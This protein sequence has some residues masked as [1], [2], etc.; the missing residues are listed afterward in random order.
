METIET[1]VLV[2]GGGAT[3]VGVARDAAMRGFSTV[4]VERK[5]LA[6]G[7]TGRYH[8]LLHSGGRYAVKDPRA[9]EECAAENVILRRVA[10]DC[11]EDTGGLFVTTPW[12]DPDFG[13]RFLAGCAATGVG[14]EEI[15]VADALRREPAVNARISRAFLVADASMDAWKLV[16]ACA[17][18]AEAHGALI[19]TYRQVTSVLRD[20]D[21]VAGA[22]VVDPRTGEETTIRARV[23][24]NAT[25]AWA[26][27]LAALAG[28]RPVEVVPGKGIMIAMNHRIVN[29]VVNR[30]TMPSDGDIIVPIRTVSVVGTTDS[31]VVDPDQLEVTQ[32]EVDHMLDEGE[33]L[34]PGFRQA[35]A[36]RVWAGAR[37]LFGA[38]P[39]GED[40][41]RDITR[42]HALIDHTERD[43]IAGFVTIT[44]GKA[45]TFR[46]MAEETMDLVGS[47]LAPGEGRPCRTAIDILPDSEPEGY[48]DVTSRLA[49]R[50]AHLQDEQ[51]VCECELVSRRD[52]EAALNR[53]PT[54]NIDDVRR[55]LRLGMG[56]C[57]GG[58]C[59]Y[60][61]TGILHGYER[62]GQSTANG[63]LLDFLQERWK[64]VHPI[65]FG[66]Q[67]RQARLDDWLYQGLMDVE[68]L[69]ERVP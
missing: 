25:G 31:P 23:T 18:S 24:V 2:V 3:G 44:G 5:D 63:A 46:L 27:Q 56:P 29:T 67:L 45:T 12:D 28:C 48:Y 42:A 55:A 49:Q 43:G 65:L 62:L 9:A 6:E 10:A 4:L 7:T 52:L 66:D 8:G 21:A 59:T 35:R 69:P 14:V 38:R 22:V 17:R 32:A 40:D 41:T 53:R 50:E 16:W 37:P 36:L 54:A 68:H 1:E 33:K 15:E 19:L 47:M 58:F 34:V 61:A 64:G 26:G 20:G 30:C 60:R 39:P 13:D 51:V 57:Q 11:I